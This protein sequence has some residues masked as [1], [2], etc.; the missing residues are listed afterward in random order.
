MKIIDQHHIWEQNP[1][2]V[3]RTIEKIG[4]VCYKSEDK[5]TDMSSMGFVER[6]MKLGHESIIEH[7]SASVRFITDR[8]VTHELVRHRLCS[9]SQESQRYVRYQNIEFI[10]PIWWGEWNEN[11]RNNWINSCSYA[12]QCY[13][14][15]IVNSN[16]APEQARTVLPN[17]VK[18]EIVVTANL[19]EWRHIF[20]L[21]TSK[22]ACYQ[23]RSLMITCLDDFKRNI[24]VIFDD[25]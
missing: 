23:I 6:I 7:V 2:D 25:I 13:R 20:K 12:E 4:R 18:T 8:S 14:C 24:P 16:I 1:K 21:R 15:M 19:R 3:L 17:S 5:I 10:R 11:T 22:K 9:F